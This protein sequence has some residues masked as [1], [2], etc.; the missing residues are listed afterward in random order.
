MDITISINKQSVAAGEILCLL[1]PLLFNNRRQKSR[2]YRKEKD[3]EL[4]FYLC[5]LTAI[6]KY[7][8]VKYK[9]ILFNLTSLI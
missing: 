6:K 2:K 7:N 8:L 9:Y 3:A 1:H 4:M 5:Y